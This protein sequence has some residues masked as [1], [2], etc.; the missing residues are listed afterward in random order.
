MRVLYRGRSGPQDLT[1]MWSSPSG[2]VLIVN[3]AILGA[4]GSRMARSFAVLANGRFTLIPG[5]T[6][7]Y[8]FPAF[9][10]YRLPGAW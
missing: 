4:P 8:Y 9:H 5:T 7:P 1:V 10:P 3:G 2:N 6:Q